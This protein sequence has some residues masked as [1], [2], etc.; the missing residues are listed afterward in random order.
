[1]SVLSWAKALADKFM[2]KPVS[3]FIGLE[4]K[5]LRAIVSWASKRQESLP[6]IIETMQKIDPGKAYMD[7]S[8]QYRT[9]EQGL[10][11]EK[12][13]AL[14]PKDVKF[15]ESIM[16]S[17][18]LRRAKKFRYIFSIDIVDMGV[19]TSGPKM[20]SLYSNKLMTPQEVIDTFFEKNFSSK[21]GNTIS[22]TDYSFYRVQKW[23][24]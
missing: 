10:S 2:P 14:W 4:R 22:Y 19:G 5:V 11:L 1:M 20:F 23:A 13:L 15:D 16:T 7:W 8:K 18:H 3:A 12:K 24:K 9:Q 17:E 6:D 21:Y